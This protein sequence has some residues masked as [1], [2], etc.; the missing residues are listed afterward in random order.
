[1]KLLILLLILS[2]A[3]WAQTPAGYNYDE[4]KA[5]GEIPSDPLRMSDGSIV[6]SPKDWRDSKRPQLLALFSEHVYGPIP[7]A[8][9]TWT[10]RQSSETVFDGKAVRTLVDLTLSYEGRSLGLPLL[11]YR[12][13]GEGPWPVFVG[14]NFCGNQT[15]YPD[16]GIPLSQGWVFNSDELGI[17]GN[18]AS[19]ESRGGRSG[20]WPVEAIVG[21]GYAL[22]TLAYG[23][24]EPDVVQG[25][26]SG[27]GELLGSRD[28]AA[29]AA[30]AWGLS[31]VGDFLEQETW[32]DRVAVMG[33]SRLGKAA[34]WAGA[35][36]S[37]F[38]LVVSNN[39]GSGGAALS[40]RN[41]GETVKATNQR[42]PHWFVA[43]FREYDDNEAELPVDQ[44]EL[45]ALMAGR[46]LY[47][48]SAEADLWADPEGE[49]LAVE[50]ARP[51]FDLVG[52]AIGYH[53]R[54]GQHN[55]TPFDWE[56]FLDFADAH[57]RSP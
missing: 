49:R 16:P 18:R 17:T 50:A 12:P 21:R 34:L 45:L 24:L 52:G 55:V 36:D 25:Y 9:V 57:W 41:F 39:S 28:V 33:H 5:G 44:H 15:V 42:F 51:V 3:A 6:G 35:N 47:V 11:I 37:R 20:R 31:R 27:V 26:G 46:N 19:V 10:A 38:G 4:S 32:V 2:A 23:D 53:R 48:A 1:M 56:R 13:P 40:K 43:K 22:C 30:W 14:M 7:R 8:P 29:I 54:P